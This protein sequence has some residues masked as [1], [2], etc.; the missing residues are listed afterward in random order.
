MSQAW[1]HQIW[2]N[3]SNYRAW[4]KKICL[5][6]THSNS[7]ISHT[8]VIMLPICQL[9]SCTGRIK[10]TWKCALT[11]QRC[12]RV[13]SLWHARDPSVYSLTLAQC[14]AFLAAIC[15][16]VQRFHLDMQKIIQSEVDK[17][18]AVG[19]IREDEYP[20]WL[21]NVVVIPK[22]DGKWRVCVDYT[23]LNDT[24]LKDSFSLP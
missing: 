19:F 16:K 1:N 20:N 8:V 12:L 18:L 2:R 23:N 17:L 9:S 10:S 22:K 3:N 21:A 4:L 14:H 15:Q 24:Y 5:Q 7:C 13:D 6:L 11:K